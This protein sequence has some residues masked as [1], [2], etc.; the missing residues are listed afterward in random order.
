MA[1]AWAELGASLESLQ[2]DPEALACHARAVEAAPGDP[3]LLWPLLRVAARLDDPVVEPVTQVL[4]GL[5][6]P[7]WPLLRRAGILLGSTRWT[8]LARQCLER[9]LQADCDAGVDAAAHAVLAELLANAGELSASVGHYLQA[10]SLA[11]AWPDLHNNLGILYRKMDRADQARDAFAAAVSMR[12]DHLAALYNLG[13]AWSFPGAEERARG[14]YARALAIDPAHAR[15]LYGLAQI[16]TDLEQRIVLHRRAIDA[17]PGLTES[18][19]SLVETRLAVCDWAAIDA[20]IAE[21]RR[22]V[23]EQPGAPITPFGFAKLTPS[24]AEQQQCA[25]NWV[26]HRVM[27]RVRTVVQHPATEGGATAAGGAEHPDVFGQFQPFD[28]EARRVARP[29]LRIGYLSADFR[30]HVVGRLLVD[31]LPAHDRSRVEVI[32][33][34]CCADDGSALRSRLVAGCDRFEDV[35]DLGLVALARRIHAL[36]IDILVDLTGFTQ[37][38]R[39]DALALRPAPVQVNWLGYPGTMGAPFIDAILA[40]VTLIPHAQQHLYDEAVVHLAHGYQ[41]NPVMV[42]PCMAGR[43]ETHDRSAWGLP[44]EG[45]VYASFNASYKLRPAMFDLWL[46]VLEQVDGSVLWLTVEGETARTRL[47]KRALLRRVDPER[48][49]FAPVVPIDVH[50]GRLP[51]ADLFLDCHPYS[52]GATASQCVGR[53]VP[54]LTLTGET[55]VSRMATAVL[56]SIGCTEFAAGTEAEYERMAV[57]LGR[58]AARRARARARVHEGVLASSLF[59]PRRTAAD[60]EDACHALWH[61]FCSSGQHGQKSALTL[62]DPPHLRQGLP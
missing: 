18:L 27:P 33:L 5:E 38:S 24:A 51:L 30:D 49:V 11:P 58:D 2:R 59:D 8:V 29:V 19:V 36:Q 1:A 60:V 37:G 20:Q 26:E 35:S 41:P 14:F 47:R 56:H 45:M 3:M 31:F 23:R 28:F 22:R 43:P 39:S 17:D 13:N 46:R 42:S 57:D 40:D 32:G 15:A 25:R 55:Y 4:L 9:G 6:P 62:P 12:P 48:L 16:T 10:I 50:L 52:A 7:D 34:G 61:A 44:A 53:G 54:L 21:V